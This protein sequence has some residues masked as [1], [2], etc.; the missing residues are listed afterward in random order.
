MNIG[1]RILN[2]LEEEGISRREFAQKLHINYSTVNGYILNRRQPDCEML[3]RIADILNSSTDYLI[4]RSNIKFY[5]DLNYSPKESLLI[6]NFRG[7]NPD[8]QDLLITLTETM[9][10]THRQYHSIW[11][12]E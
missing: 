6:S 10:Q 5:K 12:K 2:L 7:L 4:G 8:M 3:F 11:K 9:Y 1:T